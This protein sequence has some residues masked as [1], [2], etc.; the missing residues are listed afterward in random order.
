MFTA[1]FS[2]GT[3]RPR[4]KCL[5]EERAVASEERLR[6][7]EDKYE[8]YTVYDN[9]GDKIGKVDD[10]FVDESD[11][12]EYIGVKLGFLGRK[13]TLIPTEIVRVNEGDKAIE[14]S[15]S[16]DHVKDAPSFD[17]DEDITPDYESRIRSHFGLEASESSGQRGSY[18][19]PSGSSTG[20]DEG[21]ETERG[22]SDGDDRGDDRS[23]DSD[24][25]YGDRGERQEGS[26]GVTS[27]TSTG[28]STGTSGSGSSSGSSGS[29][30]GGEGGDEGG[31]SGGSPV[32]RQTEETETFEE[33]GRTKVR[34]RIV[35]EEIIEEDA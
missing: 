3:H 11:R 6:E 2:V 10:L 30:G 7:L 18:G 1:A 26:S 29:F 14:V 17:D 24:A 8:G 27:G 35:R 13:S 16:K 23:S 25:V 21:Q 20:G 5:E 22:Y 4:V 32:T 9:S 12:E 33:G 19:A 31:T 15:D 28:A 34:R